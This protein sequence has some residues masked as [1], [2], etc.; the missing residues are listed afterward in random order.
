MD[1][2]QLWTNGFP[3]LE[4]DDTFLLQVRTTITVG[5]N[6]KLDEIFFSQKHLHGV[7][8]SVLQ[9]V[10]LFHIGNWKIFTRSLEHLPLVNSITKFPKYSNPYSTFKSPGS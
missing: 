5:A 7:E 9:M 3:F 10:H 2:R 4:F 8:T 1:P 6:E